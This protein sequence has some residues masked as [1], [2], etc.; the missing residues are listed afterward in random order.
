MCYVKAQIYN[1]YSSRFQ[2]K[3]SLLYSLYTLSSLRNKENN[4]FLDNSFL[5]FPSP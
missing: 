2:E 1:D 4:F 3:P 5:I